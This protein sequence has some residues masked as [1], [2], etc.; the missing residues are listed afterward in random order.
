MGRHV[1]RCVVLNLTNRYLVSLIVAI[2]LSVVAPS[3][4]LP[5]SPQELFERA[6]T[7]YR[8]LEIVDPSGHAS[9]WRWVADAFNDVALRYP[10][11]PFASE[12]LWRVSGIYG[13][14]AL[15]GDETAAIYQRDIYRDLVG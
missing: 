7:L 6:E 15:A 8:Q 10:E 5:A 11:S 1:G 14:R 3:S 13:R 12:A 2:A 4:A 9:S